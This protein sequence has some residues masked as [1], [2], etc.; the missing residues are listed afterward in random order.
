MDFMYMLG[1]REISRDEMA[2]FLTQFYGGDPYNNIAFF[3]EEAMRYF[4][5]S[6]SSLYTDARSGASIVRRW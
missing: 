5:Y 6:G 1:Q 3:E 2:F 4:G